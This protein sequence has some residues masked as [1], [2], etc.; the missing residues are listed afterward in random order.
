LVSGNRFD[1]VPVLTSADFSFGRVAFGNGVFVA[2]GSAV[3]FSTD[4]QE[5]TFATNLTFSSITYGRG[6][7]F[8]A[9]FN[10]LFRSTD[11]IQWVQL[12]DIDIASLHSV[13]ERFH[14][15]HWA[16]IAWD[17]SETSNDGTNWTPR[18]KFSILHYINCF[19]ENANIAVAAGRGLLVSR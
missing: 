1:W 11:G 2:A 4:A 13:C 6:A 3:F 14:Y 12:P 17:D 10:H 5:W 19:A 8:G 7:F 9:N 15:R 18:L 16:A